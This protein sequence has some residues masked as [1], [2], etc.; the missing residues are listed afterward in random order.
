MEKITLIDVEL[1]QVLGYKL[2]TLQRMVT[3][4]TN[5]LPPEV[6]LGDPGKKGKRVWLVETVKKWLKEREVGGQHEE[7]E[8]EQP[9]TEQPAEVVGAVAVAV[10]GG[11]E[12]KRGR[13]RPRNVA[14]LA[15]GAAA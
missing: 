7:L 1:A 11:Q 10:V 4:Q 2:V 12:T 8:T 6:F 3:D 5:R 15:G 14:A 9:A 13:G